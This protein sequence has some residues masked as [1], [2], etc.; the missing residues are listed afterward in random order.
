MKIK[1]L[2]ALTGASGSGKS[3]ASG[4]L[5]ELGINVIDGD[6]VA[7]RVQRKGSPCL[8]ALVDVFSENILTEDGELNR[9]K[10]GSIVFSDRNKLEL[11]N[12]IVHPFVVEA[13]VSDAKECLSGGDRFCIVEAPT[14][15]ESGLIDYCDKV[16]CI[17]AGREKSIERIKARDGLSAQDASNRLSSQ[18]PS[19]A[20]RAVSDIVISNDGTL[21]DLF[22]KIDETV[23]AINAWYQ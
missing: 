3:A 12:K 23:R 21:A 8:A 10:L 18:L 16:I 11:L 1:G 22:T 5:R 15:I 14:L 6:I 2:V 20:Y 13:I 4:Y 19:E 7:R 9:K 17:E